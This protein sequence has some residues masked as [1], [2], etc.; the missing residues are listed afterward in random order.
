M[1]SPQPKLLDQVR[2]LIRMKHYSIRTEQTYISWIKRFIVFHN[3]RHPADMG[4]REIEAFLTDLAV[5]RKVAASTQN[6]AFNAII[7]LYNQ[8]LK[9]ETTQGINAMRAKMPERLPVVLSIPE[10]FDLIDAMKGAP[11]LMVQILYGAGLRGIECVRLRVKD[12]DF[13]RNE[14]TV[15][16]GKGQKD[17][18]T[19]VPTELRASLQNQLRYVKI[20]HEKD[21]ANGFG[22]VYLPF[23]LEHKYPNANR[24]WKWQYIFPSNTLSVDP[25]SGLKRRHHYHLNSLNQAIRKAVKSTEIQKQVSTHTFRHSFATHLLEDGYDIRTIQELLGHKDVSTTQIY[26]H[27]LNKGGKGVKSP[28]DKRRGIMTNDKNKK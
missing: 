10:V 3:K 14:I 7:F 22:A 17:R 11:Q 26:T 18:V 24:E 20:V 5:N 6:Q 21:L 28:L 25:R 19:M 12:I 23:A 27:V 13:D 4:T 16:R 2:S 15:R 1:K 8:V 9:A